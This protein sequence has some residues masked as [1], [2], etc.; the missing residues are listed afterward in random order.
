MVPENMLT[1][2]QDQQGHGSVS[3]GAARRAHQCKN[4][5]IV[6][7]STQNMYNKKI[8]V[9]ATVAGAAVATFMFINRVLMNEKYEK[10]F[11]VGWFYYYYCK[12]FE[13]L[14]FRNQIG[15]IIN[16]LPPNI[17]VLDFG[18]G[19]G[20]MVPFFRRQMYYGVD[21]DKTR[22]T[23]ARKIYK[24]EPS[25]PFFFHISTPPED[26]LAAY[27][28]FPA[29]F[30]DIVIFNDVV[31][32]INTPDMKRIIYEIHRVLRKQDGAIIVREPRK[33]TWFIT[34][35]I[36]DIVENGAFVRNDYEYIQ[37]FEKCGAKMEGNTSFNYIVRDYFVG[38][39]TLNSWYRSSSVVK[40]T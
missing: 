21:I 33:N 37:L 15:H 31:H 18:C 16:E 2:F 39:F 3:S 40:T 13:Q 35:F 8:V 23:Q 9:A 6:I 20:V 36:T 26:S 1:Y 25:A 17:R 29:D 22:I 4:N 34:K 32:H 11:N 27:L 19:P 30:F 28:S 12:D 24:G 38:I 10:Y 7:T 14:L 5:T